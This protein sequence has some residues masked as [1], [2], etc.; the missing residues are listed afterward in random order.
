MAEVTG[1]SQYTLTVSGCD[2][3]RVWGDDSGISP[4][5]GTSGSLISGSSQ[6][7]TI[8][9]NVILNMYN[10]DVWVKFVVTP[11]DT[12][13]TITAGDGSSV[14]GTN[15]SAV[16]YSA[17]ETGSSTAVYFGAGDTA[18]TCAAYQIFPTTLVTAGTAP[19][20]YTTACSGAVKSGFAF[21]YLTG[22]WTVTTAPGGGDFPG[23][24]NGA[25]KGIG[26]GPGQGLTNG[27]KK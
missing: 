19:G 14:A 23:K 16:T 25:K 22:T 9:G 26:T 5:P 21:T 18:P 24:G 8:T 6:V 10:P 3:I 20:T 7:Y 17:V 13:A 2:Y 1:G 15:P 27:G 4:S 11:A 12:A